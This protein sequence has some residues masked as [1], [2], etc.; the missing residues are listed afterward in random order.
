MI[1]RSK[2]IHRKII[3]DGDSLSNQSGLVLVGGQM[4]PR[5]CY[6]SLATLGKKLAYLNFAV[7]SRRTQA[8]TDEFVTKILP[9]CRPNDIIVFMEI[10]NSAHDHITDTAGTLLFS[11]VVTY[12]AQARDY[13]LKVACCTA[14]ARDMAGFD[15]ADITDRIMACNALMRADPSFC[16]LLI[17]FGALPQFDEKADC[18]NATY[19]NSS[20]HT[21]LTDVGY[22][23]LGTT[24]YN[25]LAAS[26][27]I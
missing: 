22:Q 20:D 19:Y 2:Q 16:D 10:S 7:G 15:D 27:L 6:A 17:D 24:A 23:L 12:C 8:L 14:I 4:Y 1:I 21:H 25:T 3:F 13:G 26:G 11:E 18:Q 5:T 9:S